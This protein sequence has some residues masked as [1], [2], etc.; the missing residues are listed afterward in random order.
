MLQHEIELFDLVVFT[1]DDHPPHHLSF[2]TN[3]E[4]AEA[5]ETRSIVIHDDHGVP[6]TVE[7]VMWPPHCISGTKGAQLHPE[8]CIRDKS[9]PLSSSSSFS[10]RDSADQPPKT[11]LGQE[12]TTRPEGVIL[13]GQGC[14]VVSHSPSR[15]PDQLSGETIT[16][17]SHHITSH[18]IT[19]HHITS[20]HITSHHITS[21]H[22]T[23]RHITL[24]FL[25]L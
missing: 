12:R 15:S 11:R 3:H 2:F 5:F 19:S 21:H 7:Q 23:S 9:S 8:L 4:G 6:H 17:T 18:H 13:C 24:L 10:C 20:H 22:I 1:M 14:R 16:S 25:G